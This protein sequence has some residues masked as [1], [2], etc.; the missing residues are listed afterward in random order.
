MTTRS[1]DTVAADR[2]SNTSS[3][4]ASGAK[5]RVIALPAHLRQIPSCSGIPDLV[6]TYLINIGLVLFFVAMFFGLAI[7]PF[8]DASLART[9]FLGFVVWMLMLGVI[10][11][12]VVLF[13]RA[14][15]NI[16][17]W[18]E[19]DSTGFRYGMGKRTHTAATQ[20]EQRIEWSDIVPRLDLRYDV[21]YHSASR[22]TMRPASFQFWRRGAKLESAKPVTLRTNLVDFGADNT[23]RCI[24]FK[25]RDELHLA[26]L[27]GLAHRG[28]RFNPRAFIAAGIHPETWKPLAK[29]RRPAL[30]WISVIAVLGLAAFWVWGRVSLPF[31]MSM[32][33][34][35]CGYYWTEGKYD[36]SPDIK[37]YPRDPIMFCLDSDTGSDD[38]KS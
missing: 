24:R 22:V 3:S 25:N 2:A 11:W 5:T 9:G 13:I 33:I 36:F 38:A 4:P 23:I 30:L 7:A 28:L 27:C 21:E 29:E 35:C 15:M 8:E 14:T 1:D 10:A 16:G 26:V 34:V 17:A 18:F 20:Q 37:H 6:S 12:A 19:V 32:L 31:S